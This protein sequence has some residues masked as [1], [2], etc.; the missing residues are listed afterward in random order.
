MSNAYCVKTCNGVARSMSQID[1]DH[2][3]HDN[4]H[5]AFTSAHE[6]ASAKSSLSSGIAR[7]KL[8]FSP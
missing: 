6:T 3:S 4:K 1:N 8:I 2:A 5:T 7:L